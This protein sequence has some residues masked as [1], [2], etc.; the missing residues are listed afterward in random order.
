MAGECGGLLHNMPRREGEASMQV[1]P[2]EPYPLGPT[3]DGR[4]T[5]F[6]I[7]SK[8]ADSVKLCLFDSEGQETQVELPEITGYCWHGYRQL[9]QLHRR[10]PD[11]AAGPLDRVRA[12]AD[13]SSRCLIV[14]RGSITVAANFADRPQTFDPGSDR[15]KDL[16]LS[17]N[18]GNSIQNGKVQLAPESVIILGRK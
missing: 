5:N 1:W 2:G 8:I 9:I 17:S 14:Y 10:I 6:S 18:P 13:E 7:F 4:G 11:L 16:L 15:V 3:Y 12:Q